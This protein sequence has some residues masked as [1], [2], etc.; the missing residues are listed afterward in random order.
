M[1]EYPHSLTCEQRFE[2]NELVLSCELPGTESA[3][4]TMIELLRGAEFG[5][6]CSH[7]ER[8]ESLMVPAPDLVNFGKLK[9][10]G[11]ASWQDTSGVVQVMAIDSEDSS[12][13]LVRLAYLRDY[14]TSQALALVCIG[15]Q[16]KRL[17]TGST[18]GPGYHEVR[19]IHVFDGK[20]LTLLYKTEG[21]HVNP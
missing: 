8:A 12:G 21:K 6:D 18:N 2:T 14:L 11:H 15:Y 20:T 7:D 19:T 17:I 13:L 1:G 4:I 10:D 5:Y 16:E 3:Q 9:W